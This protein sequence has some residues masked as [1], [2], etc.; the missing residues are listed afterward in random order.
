MRTHVTSQAKTPANDRLAVTYCNKL[1]PNIYR[2]L[3]LQ[4]VTMLPSAIR[5]TPFFASRRFCRFQHTMAT[6]SNT[7]LWHV[8]YPAPKTSPA[9]ICREEVLDM[10]KRSTETTSKDYILVDLR[11]ND[12]QVCS[13]NYYFQ[14]RFKRLNKTGWHYPAL[15]QPSR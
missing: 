14:A 2:Y 7:P 9:S 12:C 11:R 15:D 10:M 8:A 5:T 6:T 1:S 13:V 4:I 3:L